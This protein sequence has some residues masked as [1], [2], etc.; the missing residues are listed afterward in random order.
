[1]GC[2]LRYNPANRRWEC[3]CHGSTFD[4]L[5]QVEAAPAIRNARLSPK[6]RP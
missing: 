2:P 5:G 6:D 3:P 1:M 4:V